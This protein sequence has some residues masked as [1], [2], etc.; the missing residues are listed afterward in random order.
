V[1]Y[2]L[3][4][5]G[6]GVASLVVIFIVSRLPGQKT[7]KGVVAPIPQSAKDLLDTFHSSRGSLP[8]RILFNLFAPVLA[9][10]LAVAG[11]PY[12][13][14]VFLKGLFPR[15]KDPLAAKNHEFAVEP[16]HLQELLSIEVIEQREMVTDPLR[17]VPALPFGHLHGAW[18][19][20]L[21]RQPEGSELWS[22]SAQWGTKLGK[23]ELRK[24][25]VVVHN[26]L[27]SL[28]MTTRC[29]QVNDEVDTKAE[30]LGY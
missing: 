14:Y 30:S 15:R 22:F 23:C 6:I 5:L 9:L 26:G 16:P 3:V 24:G 11:W 19:D 20:F 13:I 21:E 10:F 1:I 12:V 18:R 29:K 28:F 7:A 2:F 17:A 4:W 27:P 25:Y 8:R